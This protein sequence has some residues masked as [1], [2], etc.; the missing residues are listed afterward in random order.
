[1]ELG[2]PWQAIVADDER[3]RTW[4]DDDGSDQPGEAPSPPPP[5]AHPVADPLAD[6]ARWQPIAVPGHW[7][8]TPAFAGTDGPLLY[9]TRFAHPAPAEGERAWLRLDGLFYQGDVWLDGGYVGDTEGYFFPHTFE[10]TDSMAARTE[11]T[12]GIEV[13]CSPQRDLTAKSTITGAFQHAE[14]LDP[15]GNPGGIWRPVTIERTGPVRIRHLRVLCREANETRATVTFRA[16][17]DAADAGEVTLRSTVG[18][19]ELVDV[20]RLAAGENQVEWQVRVD[21][22][23]LWW[24]HALGEQHLYD[25]VVEVSP[26]PPGEERLP[27]DV[28]VSHRVTRRTGLRQIHLRAWVL[29][30]NGERLFVKGTNLGPT[31]SAL[32]EAT[33]DDLVADVA[34]AKQANLDLLR[35]HAHISRPE[36]YDA[37][38]EAGLLVWQDFPL[39]RGYARTVRKQAQRQARE[40]VD[41]LGH[42]PSVALWCGH[43]EPVALDV[44]PEAGGDLGSRRGRFLAAQELPTWNKTILDRSVKRSLERADGTR[45][46]IAH[47][48]VLPHPPMLDGTDSHLSFGW[49]RADER[50]LPGF[51]RLVPRRVRFVSEFGAQAVP[52]TDGFCEPERWPDLNWERLTRAHGLHKAVFDQ[53]V[54]PSDHPTFDSWRRATQAYQAEVIRHHVETLRRLKYRPTGG[55]AQYRLA[56]GHPAVTGS[57]LDHQR[58]PKAA[59]AALRDA[60]RP[61]IVVADRLPVEVRPGDTLALD[62][63]VVSDLRIPLTGIEVTARLRWGGGEQRWRFGGDVDPDAVVRVGTLQVEVPDRAG[64]LDLGLALTGPGIADGPLERNDATRIVE[65]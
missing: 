52:E 37:V 16:V 40:A 31:R 13:T 48:G 65:R 20:R 34:L 53:R 61:V 14:G 32:A 25:V 35:V 22:P 29:H 23:H 21:D 33:V 56:D 62:V 7:R 18:D 10:I 41:L 50:D 54:P 6:P 24:P 11:H 63:H 36:L 49:H 9:R 15:D 26:H 51:A 17:L 2:G 12:L 57:I 45:P 30:V 43:N 28:P 1:M 19:V 58:V 38:D 59:Y 39:H 47:S 46:V 55:F 3:R 4:L 60:C 44:D 27:A 8:S 64:P 5:A 42:H